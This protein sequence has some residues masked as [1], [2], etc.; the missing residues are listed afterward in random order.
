MAIANRE[1]EYEFQGMDFDIEFSFHEKGDGEAYHAEQ[2]F[3]EILIGGECPSKGCIYSRPE[4]HW[5]HEEWATDGNNEDISR[6]YMPYADQLQNNINEKRKIM[7]DEGYAYASAHEMGH[8]L[9]LFD[10]YPYDDGRDRFTDNEETGVP[11]PSILGSYDN[12]MAE[13]VINKFL[14]PNDLEM[15]FK[16]Y[17]VT[18]G[19]SWT[20][21]QMYKTNADLNMVISDCILN[22][23]DYFD[24]TTLKR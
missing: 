20:H 13:R 12:I 19:K 14:M 3:N 16:A 2:I 8:A 6:I 10:A 17:A 24:D 11:E 15:M 9:G 18:E 21:L 1:Q 23:T 7:P 5:Y 22:Q 4:E